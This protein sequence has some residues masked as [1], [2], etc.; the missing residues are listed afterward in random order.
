MWEVDGQIIPAVR[1]SLMYFSIDS[2]S[3]QERLYNLLVGNGAQD[4]AYA[5]VIWPVGR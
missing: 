5:A 4:K 2:L 3:G 1:E